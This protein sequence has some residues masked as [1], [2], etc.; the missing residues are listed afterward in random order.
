MAPEEMVFLSSNFSIS[1]LRQLD[2]RF[3]MRPVLMVQSPRPVLVLQGHCTVECK[4]CLD[5]SAIVKVDQ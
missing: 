2:N 5:S 1:A 3:L 4:F